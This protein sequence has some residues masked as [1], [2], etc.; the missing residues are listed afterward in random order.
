MKSKRFQAVTCMVMGLVLAAMTGTARADGCDDHQGTSKE[1]S[2]TTYRSTD[3]PG[4]QGVSRDQE[5]SPYRVQEARETA[6]L[7]GT[8][9]SIT[10]S[11]G[12]RSYTR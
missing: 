6:D 2:K 9:R 10:D 7:P 3:H 5:Q 12:M 4:H 1:K 8:E 11:E